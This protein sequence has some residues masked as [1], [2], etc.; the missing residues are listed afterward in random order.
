[1]ARV[2]WFQKQPPRVFLEEGVLKICSKFTGK[3]PCRGTILIKLLYNFVEIA[4]WQGCSPVNL[5][6]IFRTPFLK[7]T[8]GW[9]LLSFVYVL[10]ISIHPFLLHFW[11]TGQEVFTMHHIFLFVFS[12]KKFEYFV[13][14]FTKK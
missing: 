7:S 4:L 10:K 8:S 13:D 12:Q 5:Q 14:L 3:H 11:F 9:L 1:M 6:H 2:E